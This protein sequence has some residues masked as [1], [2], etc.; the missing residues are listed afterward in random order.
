MVTS[1]F[2]LQCVNFCLADILPKHKKK[3]KSK[4]SVTK[5]L[6]DSVQRQVNI[7]PHSEGTG[8]K[9]VR[10]VQV[11]PEPIREHKSSR[12]VQSIDEPLDSKPSVRDRLD[13]KP[14]VRDRL[15]NNKPKITERLGKRHRDNSHCSDGQ[16]D[17]NRNN[18]AGSPGGDP[19]SRDSGRH[20][21][22]RSRH[23]QEPQGNNIWSRG[24]HRS[25][26]HSQHRYRDREREKPEPISIWTSKRVREEKAKEKEPPK[27]KAVKISSKVNVEDKVSKPKQ[28]KEGNSHEIGRVLT[29]FQVFCLW[30][31]T[32]DQVKTWI[33]F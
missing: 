31:N 19:T 2:G 30:Q 13:N 29:W 16:A 21:H 1:L 9:V 4:S 3:K 6:G 23:R 20:G 26:D 7:D 25:P 17:S 18:G 12:R 28:G 27:A 22:H 24:R 32:W 33:F 5:R 15:D 8:L 14:G 10:K 11:E